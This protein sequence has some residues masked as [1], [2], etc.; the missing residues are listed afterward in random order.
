[1]EDDLLMRKLKEVLLKEDRDELKEIQTI[2]NDPFRFSE[3]VAPIVEQRIDFLKKNFPKEFRNSVENIVD[4]KIKASQDELLNVLYPTIGKMIK[5]YIAYQFQLMK[6]SIDERMNAIF[7]FRGLAMRTRYRLLGVSGGDM[8]LSSIDGPVIE[9]LYVIERDSGLLMGSASL[10]LTIDSEVIAGML[11]AI[12]S[13]V[14]DAFQ[15]EKEDLEMIEYGTYKIFIQNFHSYYIAVAM[16]GSL[17]AA[18]KEKLSDSLLD[19]AEKELAMLLKSDDQTNH[20][21]I[22]ERLGKFFNSKKPN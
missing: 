19:F 7:S 15:R 13:F 8:L 16:S 6:E 18:E 1:M 3:K 14:E 10:H 12:K 4:A 21:E 2:L 17:S 5:K 11:T 20:H 22:S 9:E